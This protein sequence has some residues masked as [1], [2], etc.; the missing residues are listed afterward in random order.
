MLRYTGTREAFRPFIKVKE[1]DLLLTTGQS[2]VWW[3]SEKNVPVLAGITLLIILILGVSSPEYNLEIATDAL[4]KMR[5]PQTG[6]NQYYAKHGRKYAHT[7]A[8]K[9]RVET[10]SNP[11]KPRQN[12]VTKV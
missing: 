2:I 5:L 8:V 4:L 1:R 10:S 12:D 9:K 6:W 7:V 11:V 3:D